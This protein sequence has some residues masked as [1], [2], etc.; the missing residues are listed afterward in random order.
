[1][2]VGFWLLAICYI[3]IFFRGYNHSVTWLFCHFVT[4]SL[5]YFVTL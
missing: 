5:C 1:L 3:M 4:L 2:A